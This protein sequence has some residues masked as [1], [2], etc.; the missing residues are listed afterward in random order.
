MKGRCM[1]SCLFL[2]ALLTLN[3]VFG[4]APAPAEAENMEKVPAAPVAV[5]FSRDLE[6]PYLS[7]YYVE[8]VLTTGQQATFKYYVTDW[9]QSET[10]FQQNH[11]RFKV[12]LH[13]TE[14]N[15]GKVYK[16]TDKKVPAGDHE[17]GVGKLP[18]GDYLLKLSAE[19]KQGRHSQTIYHQFRVRKEADLVI[20]EK[21]TCYM[22]ESDLAKYGISKNGDYGIYHYIDA[23]GKNIDET[24][25]LV[26][27]AAKN[28]TVPAGKYLVVIGGSKTMD[29]LFVENCGAYGKQKPEWLPNYRSYQSSKVLYAKDYDKEKV[30]A[31]ALTTSKGLN[32][33]LKDVRNAGK[34]KLVFLPGVYRISQEE[35]LE[36]PSGLTVDLNGATIKLN[37]NAADNGT[38][39]SISNCI[40]SHVYNG[41][42][43][44][45]YFEHDYANAK[46]ESEW[47]TGIGIYGESKYCSFKDLTLRFITGYGVGNGF[48]DANFDGFTKLK[49]YTPGT[50]DRKSGKVVPDVPGLYLSDMLPIDFLKNKFGCFTVSR[51]LGYQGIAMDSRNLMYHFFDAGQKYLET[52]DGEQYRRVYPPE[53]A[54][55]VR[56]TVWSKQM[57]NPEDVVQSNFFKIPQNCAFENLYIQN[58]RAVGMAPSAMYNMKIANCTIVRSGETLA[59]CAFD[60]EDG[61]DM[62]QD[63]WIYRNR[64]V[65]NHHNGLLTCAGNN[66]VIEENQAKDLYLWSRTNNYVVRNNTFHHAFLGYASRIRTGYCRVNNNKLEALSLGDNGNYDTRKAFEQF[67]KEMQGKGDVWNNARALVVY[68]DTVSNM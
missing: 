51:T 11:H 2:L 59:K 56:V 57:P 61:W 27:E 12:S 37:Q 36:I 13:I 34:R 60:A 42:V 58:A 5:N 67:E 15:T 29:D 64:F 54:Q 31:E 49:N 14:Q 17:I 21:D 25:V 66:F 35:R 33:L 46:N 38:I 55:F 40:D 63:V 26:E 53:K 68:N 22:Q 30:E 65:G 19:D 47:L 28:L 43:E 48:M 8:P 44:G 3:L 9:Y 39:I 52:I 6:V 10:R 32:A 62:M 24:K 23:T 16:K 50:I 41:I 18:A 1:K 7:I 4:Q 20:P 45:D